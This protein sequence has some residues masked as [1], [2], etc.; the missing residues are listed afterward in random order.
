M[1][2]TKECFSVSARRGTIR[3][4]CAWEGNPQA[5][6][7][8]IY[9]QPMARIAT[10]SEAC[11]LVCCAICTS[12]GEAAASFLSLPL[13]HVCFQPW[14]LKKVM[15]LDSLPLCSISCSSDLSP[16]NCSIH[17]PT[18]GAVMT[19][20]PCTCFNCLWV[21]TRVCPMLVKNLVTAA[22]TSQGEYSLVG[23]SIFAGAYITFY[24]STRLEI[25]TVCVQTQKLNFP[26]CS[27]HFINPRSIV[28]WVILFSVA[29][30]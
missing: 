1:P 23:K 16:L 29:F 26:R 14:M 17:L 9:R 11:G 7:T 22:R 25:F 12:W 6:L 10:A 5:C 18:I 20:E 8:L 30:H 2:R 19:F 27:L 24:W 4:Y 13:P 28:A 15:L 21:F 3:P